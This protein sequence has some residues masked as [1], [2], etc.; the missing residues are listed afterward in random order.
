MHNVDLGKRSIYTQAAYFDADKPYIVQFTVQREPIVRALRSLELCSREVGS[1]LEH[2]LVPT[3]IS[4]RFDRHGVSDFEPPDK[5]PNTEQRQAVARILQRTMIR[6]KDER[7]FLP[8]YVIFGPPGTGKTKTMV[9]AV[10]QV[11]RYLGVIAGL[12]VVFNA[13]FRFLVLRMKHVNE[14]LR[15]RAINLR[16]LVQE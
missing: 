5:D 12:S 4:D 16:L 10:L 1:E 8:P 6:K 9:E 14:A 15:D 13:F 7:G 3:G 11:G 2:L